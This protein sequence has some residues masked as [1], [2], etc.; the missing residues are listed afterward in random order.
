VQN[1]LFFVY[2]NNS[3]YNYQGIPEST[4]T[5]IP[6]DDKNKYNIFMEKLLNIQKTLQYKKDNIHNINDIKKLL[7]NNIKNKKTISDITT[8]NDSL[9]KNKNKNKN[10]TINYSNTE[11]KKIIDKLQQNISDKIQIF[12]DKNIKINESISIEIN[13]N[14]NK[15]EN[16]YK[17]LNG[18]KLGG[19][20]RYTRKNQKIKNNITKRFR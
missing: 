10:H 4:E 8:F 3:G 17:H 16:I 18:N 12:I 7:D 14:N 20:R 2:I 1:S 6:V 11:L 5:Y 15:I 13:S 9:N 19:T